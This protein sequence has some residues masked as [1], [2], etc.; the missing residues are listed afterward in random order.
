M[1]QVYLSLGSNEGLRKKYMEAMERELSCVLEGPLARSRLME[2]EPLEIDT[3]Q[4]C[5]LNAVVG[6]LYGAG[7]HDLLYTCKDIE[8]RLGRKRPY[9]H[10][11]R[12]ADIDILVFGDSV[13]N[14]DDLCLPHPALCRRRFC[15]EGLNQIAPGLVIPGLNITVRDIYAGLP[16]EVIKQNVKFID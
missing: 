5:F 15:M 12:T 11:P 8:I 9:F 14:D 3:T 2:T 1:V 16:E 4:S 13:M 7:A 6:G 10:A